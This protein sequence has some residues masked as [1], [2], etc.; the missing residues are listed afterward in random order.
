MPAT[1]KRVI[2]IPFGPAAYV[3]VVP[4]DSYSEVGFMDET[5]DYRKVPSRPMIEDAT[6][7]TMDAALDQINTARRLGYPSVNQMV[8]EHDLLHMWIAQQSGLPWS[9]V[10]HGLAFGDSPPADLAA[11]E[12][13]DALALAHALNRGH[14]PS[15]YSGPLRGLP[16]EAD[17]IESARDFL[18]GI[19]LRAW[20]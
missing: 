20:A 1:D 11:S 15:D 7:D 8:I 2:S 17:I 16:N 6:P 5:G 13:A 14:W 3:S 10:L 4:A 19:G 18:I 12:E 9:P